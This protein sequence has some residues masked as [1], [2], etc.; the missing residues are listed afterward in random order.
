MVHNSNNL[1]QKQNE[2]LYENQKVIKEMVQK[3]N[4]KPNSTK[5]IFGW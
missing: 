3:T 5:V 4:E 2:I 1:L